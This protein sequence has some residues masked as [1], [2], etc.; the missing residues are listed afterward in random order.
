MA[1][2]GPFRS[3]KG[4]WTVIAAIFISVLLAMMSLG[5]VDIAEVQVQKTTASTALSA[6]IRAGLRSLI[7]PN[8]PTSTRAL[9]A[10]TTFDQTLAENLRSIAPSSVQWTRW[11]TVDSG[12]VDPQSKYAFTSPG[13]VAT[14]HLLISLDFGLMV[15]TVP[16]TIH[17]DSVIANG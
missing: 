15:A 3:D 2:T 13:A 17:A 14:V 12:Y 4:H 9:D 1:E 8:G 7:G 11:T 5:A 10:R 16:L 6:A